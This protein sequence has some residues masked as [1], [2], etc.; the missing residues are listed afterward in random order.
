MT[1]AA[2]RVGFVGAGKSTRSRHIPGFRKLPGVELVAVANR[3]RE[4]GER[5]AKEFGIGRVHADWRELVRAPDVDAVCIGT[6][7]YPHREVTLAALEHGVRYT[8]FTEAVAKSA[9]LGRVAEVADR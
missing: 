5:V 3:T 1:D 7:P 9:S 2:I 8:E 4:S 6:W